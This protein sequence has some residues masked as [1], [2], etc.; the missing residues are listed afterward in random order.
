MV[1]CRDAGK[2]ASLYLEGDTL[3]LELV[4]SKSEPCGSKLVCSRWCD[5]S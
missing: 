5:E 3:V 2:Q 4:R 1:A